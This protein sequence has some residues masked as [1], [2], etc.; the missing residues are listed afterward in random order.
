[1]DWWRLLGLIIQQSR[2]LVLTRLPEFLFQPRFG[3]NQLPIN[4]SNMYFLTMK[5]D[6]CIPYWKKRISRQ[7]YQM[8]TSFQYC[9]WL[10]WS[11]ET[12]SFQHSLLAAQI[13]SG[14]PNYLVWNDQFYDDPV[15][16]VDPPCIKYCAKPWGHST[17]TN[18][19]ESFWC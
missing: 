13:Y 14:A 9:L 6:V 3:H 11:M 4:Y 7:S 1:M 19:I 8:T 15:P 16:K 5:V 2:P 18:L 10:K 12:I 17:V